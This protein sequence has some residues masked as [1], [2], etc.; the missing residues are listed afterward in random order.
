MGA[1]IKFAA[2]YK[3]ETEDFALKGRDAFVAETKAPDYIQALRKRSAEKVRMSGLPTPKL[4][5]FKYFN[6]PAYLK[7]HSLEFSA[8]NV[9]VSGNSDLIKEL[10]SAWELECV[11]RWLEV[12]PAG[13]DKYGDMMLWDLANALIANGHVINVP[14]GQ[15]VSE[16][17]LIQS[18]AQNGSASAYRQLIRAAENSEVTIIENQIGQGAYWKNALTQIKVEKGA[19]VRLFR[20]QDNSAEGIYTQNTHVEVEQGG[21]YEEFTLTTGAAQSRN[22]VHVELLG[23]GA[24]AY[25]NGINL[26]SGKQIGDTTITVEHKAPQCISKQNYRSV[27]SEQSVGIF[28]GKVHVHQIAQKTDGYQLSNSLLLSQAAT[29]NTKPE[30]EIYADDVKCSHGATVG[31]M[32]DEALFYLKSRG[33]S[34]K[35]ARDLLINAFVAEVIEEI[36]CEKIRENV[37]SVISEWLANRPQE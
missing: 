1:A 24:D 36:S 21:L 7:K 18:D 27:L 16:P 14:E 33:I 32:D 11:Q 34:E 23:E 29:M 5:R 12:A 10:T 4:E 20:M 28:Q 30:L 26:L 22:Q 15:K 31:R 8:A 6:L 13:E 2:R 37:S 25:V 19:R 3:A 9:E 35:K 17:I